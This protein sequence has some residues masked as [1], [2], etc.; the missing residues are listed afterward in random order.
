MVSALH[1]RVRMADEREKVRLIA[2]PTKL[3][4]DSICLGRNITG[5]IPAHASI[6]ERQ[7][8]GFFGGA[9]PICSGSGVYMEQ[10]NKDEIITIFSVMS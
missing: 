9:N 1:L 10:H 8:S 2:F 4:R 5:S 3:V 7:W 6:F